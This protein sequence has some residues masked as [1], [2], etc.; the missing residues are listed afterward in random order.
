M[1]TL[2][3]G[4]VGLVLVP[5]LIL[6]LVLNRWVKYSGDRMVQEEHIKF[7]ISPD[8]NQVS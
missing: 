6:S 2:F 4:F 5:A 1:T 3:M 7:T 8:S